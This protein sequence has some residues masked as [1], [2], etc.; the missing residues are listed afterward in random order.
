[1]TISVRLNGADRAVAAATVDALIAELKIPGAP[2]GLAVAV[3]GALVP[4]A[5][6]AA[7]DLRAGDA[8][9]IVRATQG[10]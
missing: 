4:R 5:H 2:R 7:R 8:I 1:M 10:G 3:N 6:W 9:E